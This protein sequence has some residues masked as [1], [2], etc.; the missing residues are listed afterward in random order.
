MGLKKSLKR[1]VVSV[2]AF[3][4]VAN[5]FTGR[6]ARRW[7]RRV[8]RSY[9][10]N[11]NYSFKEKHWAIKRGFLPEQVEQL[12]LTEE[13][14]KDTISVKDYTYLRPLNGIYTK[15]ISDRV[16]INNVF[17][18]YRDV[19]PKCYYQISKRYAD[20]MIIPL[21]DYEA[22]D[23]FEDVF[24][25]IKEIGK[26]KI[27]TSKRKKASRIKWEN[28]QFYLDD[29]E[30]AEEKLQERIEL[31][32]TTLV[33][34]EDADIAEEF[35]GAVI[36]LIVF[37]EQGDNPVIGDAYVTYKRVNKLE[38]RL[39]KKIKY[40][41]LD[42]EEEEEEEQKKT[43]YE[44]ENDTSYSVIDVAEIDDDTEDNDDLDINLQNGEQIAEN[45][46]YSYRTH[47][48]CI[49]KKTGAISKT[50]VIVKGEHIEPEEQINPNKKEVLNEDG[51]EVVEWKDIPL[52]KKVPYW[53]EI[54]KTVDSMC[55][56]VPQLEY[57]GLQI[58]ICKDGF[59]I[60]H[61]L[62]HPA[63]PKFMPF[64][65]ET[66]DYLKYK[67]EQKRKAYKGIGTKLSRGWKQIVL[68]VRAAYAK[69][70]FPKGMLPYLTIKFPK[71]VRK[72]FFTNK[73]TT[74][75]E[76]IWAIRHGFISYRLHQ[77]GITDENFHEYISDFEYKW[78][79]HINPSY[80]VW[81]EDKI[82][83]K[84]ICSDYNYCFP[85]Y[86]Y[87]IS[88]KNGNN[89]I[90]PMMDCPKEYS[91]TYDD[92]FKLVKEK[93]CLALKPDEGSHG[94]GFYKFAYEDGKYL[95]NHNEA[96]K[97]D[98]LNILQDVN[99]QYLITEYID[100][101]P[102]IKNIYDGAVNTIRMIVFKKDGKNPVIGN[103]Y[104]R[105][106]S[107]RTG[108]VDNMGA[109]GMFAKIDVETGKFYDA[110]IIEANEIK[111]CLYH[112]DTGVEINGYLPNWE[113]VKADVLNVA[114]SIPQLEYFGFDLAITPDGL[115]FPEI[116]RFP[117]YPAIEKYSQ[118]TRE[119]L[120]YKLEQKKISYGSKDFRGGSIIKLP[121][122]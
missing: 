51:T 37:N 47:Y 56:F 16:T 31:M 30:I 36:N 85:E 100:M 11:K 105:F 38:K 49:D 44:T 92:I 112:P 117:D 75:K 116:N 89:K 54:Q 80:R 119:Y 73:D 22:G 12:H 39:F 104:M 88:L 91:N 32:K 108:A 19:M 58:M 42:E 113:K 1:N 84:Y 70:F 33:I 121:K 115:K 40:N 2:L 96:Q 82:T 78:L 43:D 65:K 15:W 67:V 110:K 23:T 81:M 69:A 52:P 59:K 120:L 9:V 87:H 94:D 13:N 46:K 35:T 83:V 97:E 111:P 74:L 99:N 66:S 8:F 90:V 21:F 27:C 61:I 3:K 24:N 79:R 72:D 109:G 18:P 57:F 77:Y 7:T 53:D 10:F 48:A 6:A 68:K 114:R 26:V 17:K 93:G 4:D 64:S 34:M 62:N 20:T 101:H 29:I 63:Y 86:Y 55:R 25:K 14:Y 71:E 95:L 103:A 28:N 41:G 118:K 98:V 107:K 5:G 122:R 102:V 50:I 106:G 60:M 45:L 76:K